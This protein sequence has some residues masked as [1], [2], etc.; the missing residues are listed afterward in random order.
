MSPS[1]P[2]AIAA[3]LLLA[4][5]PRPV[6]RLGPKAKPSP[7][8]IVTLAPSLTETVLALGAG[9]RIVG[10][11]RFDDAPEVKAVARV[12][13]YIDPSVEAVLARSPD[14]VLVEPNP[15]SQGAVEKIARLGAPVLAVQLTTQE[16]I[17]QA[18]REVGAA[19]GLAE[20]G[21]RL[22]RELAAKVAAVTGKAKGLPK[23]RTL[24]V[25]D[26]EPLIVA[27]PGSFSDGLLT[28]VGGLNAAA[29]AKSAYPVYSVE[30]A[31]QSAPEVIVDAADVHDAP[32]ERLLRL[33]G[34][35]EAR[36]VKTSPSLFRPGPR[37]GDA[38][39]ELFQVLHPAPP[40]AAPVK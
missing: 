7:Q 6:S 10:V 13:G 29:G 8:R 39:E 11:S 21:E 32:R 25:Y 15:A 22:A 3:A 31:M 24:I 18:V 37:L 30:L 4:A 40:A 14:L 17:L 33:P 12:G 28:A 26:W 34:L 16:E 36:V 20:A 19:L 27:G 9:K 2:L 38:V 1:S 35:R 23:V 5:A